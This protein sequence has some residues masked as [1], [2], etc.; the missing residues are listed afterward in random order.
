MKYY[1]IVCFLYV[2]ID[3]TL[4]K[5]WYEHMNESIE[6]FKKRWQFYLKRKA[7]LDKYSDRLSSLR[8]F[9]FLTG[10]L[11]TGWAFY[12]AGQV[13]G[14]TLL[15]ISLIVFFA[16]VMKHGHVIKQANRY[17]NMAKINYQCMQRIEGDWT[18][19]SDDGKEYA[20]PQ[21]RYVND[22]D[23]F[24]RNSLFQWI[25][26][27]H[28]YHGR[29]FIRDWLE[30]PRQDIAAIKKRQNAIREL[31][32]KLD[33]TQDLQCQG[34]DGADILK[35]PE[36]L[37]A[38]A[39]NP[40]KLFRMEWVKAIF[41]ILPAITIAS[42]IIWYGDR[43]ISL[44]I[45]L[46]LFIIQFIIN[47]CSGKQVNQILDTVYAYKNKVSVYQGLFERIEKEK[48]Q[49]VFL[50]EFQSGLFYKSE[51]ASQQIKNLDKI[52]GAIGF[53]YN[54]I[55]FFILN[56]TLFWDFH[57]AF[58]LERWKVRSGKS[59]RKW[60]YYLGMYEALSS[61]ALIAQLNPD[62]CYPEFD[63]SKLLI[64]AK[65]MGHP[66]IAEKNRV[67]NQLTVEDQIGVVTGSN[68]SG[69][70]TLLRTIG[71]NLVLA[72]AGAPVCARHFTCSI[73]DI[74]TSMRIS[75]DL[76]SGIS[77]F[78][79]ELLRIKMIIDYAKNQTPM[80]F[81]IDEL[82]RG[83]NSRDRVAGAGNVLKNLNKGWIIGLISTHDYELCDF[84]NDKSGRIK[85]YHFIETYVQDEIKFDYLLR[86]GPCK[87]SN[88]R[89]LMRMVG[90]DIED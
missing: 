30:N 17:G 64:K 71:I 31:A 33:F 13:H 2:R 86:P 42:F 35:N 26:T 57:C 44:Y 88:A 5:G 12:H 68:M 63:Q 3:I 77:T 32:S 27:S 72:Y 79:A 66:L 23:I 90:I 37:F 36:K 85:N 78:Y 6:Q 38:Y 41:Y 25:N 83:T 4:I 73:L 39:E 52:V 22:L 49:D 60:V 50:R 20:N 70:T 29:A 1:T 87:T 14:I 65:D 82:F 62:W 7:K 48:F 81:L 54:P 58:A 69:K 28:T 8:L 10:A 56:N 15:C 55:V 89:Y 59:L 18:G 80:I 19:F 24:G 61:M 46:G 16:L 40:E 34:M 53:K 74:F 67:T 9:C 45:P 76:N 51:P 75:D 21:H 84:E 43:S 47:V 11:V